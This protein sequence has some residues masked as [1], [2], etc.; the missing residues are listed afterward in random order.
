MKHTWLCVD[1]DVE[2]PIRLPTHI[3]HQHPVVT[4]ICESDPRHQEGRLGPLGCDRDS[5]RRGR[6]V[7]RR[8][9]SGHGIELEPLDRLYILPVHQL[10]VQS[11]LGAGNSLDFLSLVDRFEVNSVRDDALDS[12]TEVLDDGL[13][14]DEYRSLVVPL[15]RPVH[16]EDT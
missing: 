1:D 13:A 10:E 4:G 5:G 2:K 3:L 8:R 7:D 14:R 12:D 11:Y 15:V 16:I 6:S 9:F